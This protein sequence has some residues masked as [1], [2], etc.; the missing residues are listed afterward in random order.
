MWRQKEGR[1]DGRHHNHNIPTQVEAKQALHQ[2]KISL[3]PSPLSESFTSGV[4]A[5]GSWRPARP[6][7]HRHQNGVALGKCVRALSGY[8]LLFF[9]SSGLRYDHGCVWS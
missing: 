6:D 2:L 9:S 1:G 8:V 4:D 3:G 5:D 7:H